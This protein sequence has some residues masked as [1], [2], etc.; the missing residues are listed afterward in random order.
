MTRKRTAPRGIRNLH[1]RDLPSTP[2]WETR[3]PDEFRE[4][5]VANLLNRITI[6]PPPSG[7]SYCLFPGNTAGPVPVRSYVTTI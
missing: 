6:P 7:T 5:L 3:V 4:F 1:L 2:S